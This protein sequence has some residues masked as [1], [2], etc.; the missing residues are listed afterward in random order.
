MRGVYSVEVET[1]F[2]SSAKTVILIHNNAD[3][4]VLELL[5]ASITNKDQDTGEQLH[6]GLFFVSSS[7]VPSGTLVTPAKHEDRDE[8]S[9][10]L[11]YGDMVVEPTSYSSVPIDRQGFNTL[12]GYRY[13][14]TPEERVL[15]KPGTAVGLRL[16]ASPDTAFLASCKL[17][18]RE[19]GGG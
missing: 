6:A 2:L 16:L 18:F 14:P 9:V 3:N 7:G 5:G 13:E 15:V 8:S 12:V 11:S 10:V 4:T 1:G 17:T 19:I